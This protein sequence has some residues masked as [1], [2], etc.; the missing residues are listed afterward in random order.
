MCG[1]IFA[2][3][4]DDVGWFLGVT[5]MVLSLLLLYHLCVYLNDVKIDRR[6][7]ELTVHCLVPFLRRRTH[8]YEIE[9]VQSMTYPEETA[10]SMFVYFR[11]SYFFFPPSISLELKDG[12][13]IKFLEA[14]LPTN[15][16]K[17]DLHTRHLEISYF[18]DIPYFT[19]KGSSREG[20]YPPSEQS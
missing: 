16:A 9:D 3:R 8:T 19:Y 17:R 4:G 20:Y 15:D 1:M 12:G 6:R 13:S 14:G 7:G 18:M 2:S 10:L 11:W 5:F